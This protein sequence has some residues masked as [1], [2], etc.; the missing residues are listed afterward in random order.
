MY[1][2]FARTSI[3]NICYSSK[4]FLVNVLKLSIDLFLSYTLGPLMITIVPHFFSLFL[5][6]RESIT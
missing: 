4:T 2:F 5:R 6:N 3:E 1:V